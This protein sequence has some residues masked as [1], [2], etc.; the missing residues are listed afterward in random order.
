ME[1]TALTGQSIFDLALQHYGSVEGV[2]RLWRD[3]AGINGFNQD[4]TG[5]TVI[6][7]ANPFNYT[8]QQVYLN[9]G[10]KPGGPTLNTFDFS[11]DF[12]IDFEA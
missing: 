2:M 11:L 4:I 10:I 9:K 3:N 1:A 5:G 12:S 7:L 8:V 6:E